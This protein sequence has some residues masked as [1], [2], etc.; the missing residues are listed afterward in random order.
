M[1]V[2]EQGSGLRLRAWEAP[3]DD[4]VPEQALYTHKGRAGLRAQVMRSLP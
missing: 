4:A 3:S 2:A 1:S